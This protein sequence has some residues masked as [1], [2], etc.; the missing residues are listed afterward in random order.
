MSSAAS[1]V[2]AAGRGVATAAS[3]QATPNNLI[4]ARNE[5]AN[6]FG[7]L[8]KGKRNWQIMA[9]ALTGLLAMVTLAY[10]RVRDAEHTGHIDLSR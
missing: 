5:F 2:A 10:V 3:D 4:T 9:F 1:E 7:D 8:A 6:A